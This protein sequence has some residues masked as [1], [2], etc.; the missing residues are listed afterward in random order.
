MIEGSIT[1]SESSF[2]GGDFKYTGMD[3][4]SKE[5]SVL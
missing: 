3:N 4:N 5:M 1:N 2:Q